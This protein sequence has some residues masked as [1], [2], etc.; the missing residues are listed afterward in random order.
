ML[1]DYAIFL[2]PDEVQNGKVVV[3]NLKERTQTITEIDELCLLIVKSVN[4]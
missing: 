3:K 4:S 1:L 2:A